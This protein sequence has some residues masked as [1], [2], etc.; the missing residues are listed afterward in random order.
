VTD[1][2][3]LELKFTAP[4]EEGVVAFLVGEKQFSEDRVR[5]TLK[6]LKAAKVRPCAFPKSHHCLLLLV[7][8]TTRDV[9]SIASTSNVYWRTGNSYEYITN[10]LFAHTVHP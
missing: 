5:S 1:C 9:R 7:E 10:A 2:E 3:G 8:Y 4:D 6:K